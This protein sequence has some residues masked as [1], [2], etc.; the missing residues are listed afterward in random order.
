MFRSVCLE[1]FPNS[2]II[3]PAHLVY[4]TDIVAVESSRGISGKARKSSSSA[5]WQNIIPFH[6]PTYELTGYMLTALLQR[7][8]DT[9]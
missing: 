4:P 5:I 3:D 8:E 6:R 9:P 7:G 2:L 1:L